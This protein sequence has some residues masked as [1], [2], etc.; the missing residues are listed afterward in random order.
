MEQQTSNKAFRRIN[1]M[2]LSPDQIVRQQH[3]KM[4][5]LKNIAK[6]KVNQKRGHT[7]TRLGWVLS[8]TT[9]DSPPPKDCQLAVGGSL[10]C[11]EEG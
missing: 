6:F 3:K 2:G 4:P 7:G 8:E 9:L 11:Q 10:G 1:K 5:H